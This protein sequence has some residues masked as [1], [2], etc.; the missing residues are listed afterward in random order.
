MAGREGPDLREGAL[1]RLAAERHGAAVEPAERA[2][3]LRPPPAAAGGL[4]DELRGQHPAE[5]A[6]L[7]LGEEIVEVRIR[8]L[9][10]DATNFNDY[11]GNGVFGRDSH[12]TKRV[13]KPRSVLLIQTLPVTIPISFLV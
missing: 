10:T 3:L 5:A 13:A 8:R 7:V 11:S 2:V 4:Q 12:L 6:R 1:G 9:S